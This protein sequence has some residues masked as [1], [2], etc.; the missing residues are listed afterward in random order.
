LIDQLWPYAA[1]GVWSFL[2]ATLLPL[3]SEVALV[4]QIKAGLGIPAWLIVAATIGNVAGSLFNWWLGLH[5]RHYET[6]AWF[7]IA[8]AAIDKATTHFARWG[9]WSLLL[10]WLPVIGDPLTLVAGIL[11]VPLWLFLPLV[12]I[13]KAARYLVIASVV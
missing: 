8:P 7:P 10:A 5:V 2:A 3:G 11:R 12:T 6:R 1:L 9:T 4:G 13:G